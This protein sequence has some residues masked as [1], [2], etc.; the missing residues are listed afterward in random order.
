M[1]FLTAGD[2]HGERLI[3]IIEGFP[4]GHR[5][6]I[7]DIEIDLARRRKGYGRSA[8]Q[9]IERDEV[10]VVSGLWRGKT[11]G[12]PLALSIPNL[13]L[14]VSGQSGG[15]LGTVP[16]PGHAD[17]AGCLKYDFVEVPPVAE[18]SSARST[19]MRV[20]IGSLAKSVLRTF[21]IDVF[22]HVISIGGVDAARTA[23]SL[24]RLKR[25]AGR[26][27]VY[28]ADSTA[29]RRMMETIRRAKKEG[30]SLGGA[31]EVIA[32]GVVPGLGSYAECDRRL[33]ARLAGALMSIQSVKA[34]E[35]GDGLETFRQKG[36]EANDEISVVGRKV[37][38]P[39]NHAGGIEGGIS[40]GEDI[41]VR[42][43]AKPIPT[44]LAR[45]PSI[46]MKTIKPKTSPFVRSDTCVIPALAVIA[47]AVTAWEI[48]GAFI[49]KFG[50]DSV[51][52]MRSSYSSYESRLRKRGG[53]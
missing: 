43:Y 13:G 17:L 14:K 33:D 24:E 44:S 20:A 15:A 40:N 12:A 3:G 10:E 42:L 52:D 29:S 7:R 11:T 47:E 8:R 51:T 41:V 36:A 1:R 2:S 4:A 9:K 16:R 45:L 34:V 48:L 27:P 30:H 32:S 25:A 38:R 46:D 49:D 6:S 21:S 26:S 5:V 28:T 37:V 19:A 53:R 31:V 22:G 50:G 39:T 18:R 35:I 23:C